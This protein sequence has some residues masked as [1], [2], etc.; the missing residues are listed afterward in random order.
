MPTS[1]FSP[2]VEAALD[3]AKVPAI[4]E[5]QLGDQVV[6]VP[7]PYPSPEDWRDTPIYFLL[8]D[9]FNN[10]NAPPRHLPWNS[11]Y[12]DFQGGT[13][14]GVRQQ[15]DYLQQLGIGAI[16][17]SPVLKNCQ[18]S[19][20]YHGYGIQDFLAIDPRFA[21]DPV[22]ARQNPA[23]VETELRRLVDEAHARGIYIIFDIVLHHTGDVFTYQQYG[24]LAPWS[25]APYPIYWHDEHG[26]PRQDWPEAPANPSLDAAI[27]PDELR[28][29]SAFLR[30]G[31]A[32]GPDGSVTNPAGDFF[33]L[34]SL[35][36][37]EQDSTG[38]PVHNI[39]IRT[40]QYLIA[41]FDIDGFRIDTV[42]YISADFAR[43]FANSIREYAL[44]IGK[45]NF[46]IFGE[47]YDN[48]DTIA[49]F[50]GR[51]TRITEAGD[52]I[53]IDAALDFPLFYTLPG[54][55]K[56]QLP[57]SAVVSM[58]A[59]RK[60]VESDILSTHGDASNFFVT[61]LD[62]H[63]QSSRFF[64]RNPA[65][66][67]AFDAQL[68]LGVACLF[69]LPGIPCLYYGT[70]QGLSGAGNV[71]EAVREALWGKPDAFDTHS[72]FYIAIAQIA[73]L[74]QNQPAL[75]Y[76]RY[77]FRPLSGDGTYFGI[78]TTA[79][80]VLAFSR[81]LNDQEV[82]IIANTS[83]TSSWSGQVIIDYS[84]NPVQATYTILYSNNP[85]PAPP[86]PLEDKQ[87]N[88]IQVTEVNGSLTYGPARVLPVQLAPMEV[89]ILCRG[90]GMG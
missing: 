69:A 13:I 21:S 29:N 73:V 35:A 57:P 65:H 53:G 46:F 31:N 4:R 19:P 62:N 77:Y 47:I 52:I 88:T 90:G 79:P 15:L 48:E 81:I 87:A 28:H 59:H 60:L 17:L 20:S 7:T 45:K 85:H 33:S 2:E 8:V 11:I 6:R 82:L 72:Q 12:G 71:P 86:S 56:G 38:Y 5:V 63:D 3:Q 1:I 23:L 9:R 41:R 39:L 83:P 58:Y 27:W 10:P 32:F 30:Q 68:S 14:E 22:Q 34:K 64:Y 44:S 54:V 70:E 37:D 80:G 76:G 55:C 43:L 67:D 84:L 24:D 75:R 61:F 26:N 78:S 40:F 66:P 25:N 89:Q 42:K 51:N 49:Q 74:R 50:I 16:W 36:T 18:Y